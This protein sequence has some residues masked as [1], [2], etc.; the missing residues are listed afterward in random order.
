LR[1][2]LHEKKKLCRISPPL[3]GM[4]AGAKKHC[5][6]LRMALLTTL[7][8]SKERNDGEKDSQGGPRQV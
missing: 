6:V 2:I 8:D 5:K 3:K 1:G 4:V 7:L